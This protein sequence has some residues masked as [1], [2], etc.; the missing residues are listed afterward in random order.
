MTGGMNVPVDGCYRI[1]GRGS[2]VA[3]GGLWLLFG[4]V[5]KSL[6]VSGPR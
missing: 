3:S 4:G 6:R 5:I 2:V 1:R